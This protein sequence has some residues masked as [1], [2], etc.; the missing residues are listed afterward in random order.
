MV[1]K[2]N[3][4]GSPSGLAKHLERTDTNE[5]MRVIEIRGV[6]A[7]DL[8]GA[9][10]EMDAH[11]AAL[12][13]TRT[14]YHA[15]INTRADERMTNEQLMR[16][17]DQLEEK[18]GLTGQARAVVMHEKVD[19]EHFHVVWARTDLDHM[20]AIRCDHNYRKHEEVARA[21]EQEFG[22]A[23]VQ[24][25]HVG[26]DGAERPARTPSHAEMQQAE[27]TGLTPDE[28][29][30]QITALWQRTDNGK[31]FA[32][33]LEDQGWIL[34]R[35]DRRDFVVLDLAGEPHSLAKRV[36]GAKMKD[37][38][39]RMADVDPASLPSV[40]EA[41]A[42]QRGKPPLGVENE[43]QAAGAAER[44][45]MQ[46]P[47]D[48]DIRRQQ[49]REQE[50]LK[51]AEAQTAKAESYRKQRE[52]DIAEAQKQEKER[53]EQ[54]NHEKEMRAGDISDA[55]TRYSAALGNARGGNVYE[56]LA[57][58]ALAEGAAFKK[59]QEGL[60]KEAAA[61]KDPDKRA[62]IDMRR[63]IEAHEYMAV[64]SQR[65]AGI[66]AAIAGR[67]NNPISNNDREQAA[68][69]QARAKELREERSQRQAEQERKERESAPQQAA[70]RQD[71]AAR[72]R[73]AAS[74]NAPEQP[75]KPAYH[76]T[77]TATQS[78]ET[79]PPTKDAREAARAAYKQALDGT[80]KTGKEADGSGGKST[81]QTT[82]RGGGRGR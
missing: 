51:Q 73:E 47:T 43:K 27:R 46:E 19:R 11:G 26:R 33:A 62:L 59:E 9:L 76:Q 68:A 34:A 66:S 61:E 77:P 29:K 81:G 6:V 28:A 58:A 25:A 57:N 7:N 39:A 30:E 21:L 5:R 38:R 3:P 48:E 63:Q 13:T 12:R 79:P 44:G 4:R 31:A 72:Y 56:T 8:A 80:V 1:I 15:S 52:A 41:R 2:G 71:A 69:H 45:V 24:G 17:V 37:V 20:R 16:S 23:R 18:L 49:Q 40:D 74:R 78:A 54:A 82:G 50:G 70:E 64:T 60:R 22:H 36:E 65:L 55:G 35:G 53:R 32:A 75:N 14:L 42:Q 10:D 67:D